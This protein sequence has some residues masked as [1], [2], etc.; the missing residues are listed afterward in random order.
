MNEDGFLAKII[1]GDLPTAPITR[2]LSWKFIE[3][4]ETTNTISVEMLARAEFINPAGLVHGGMLAAM[5][6]ETIAPAVA[7]TLGPGEFAP[8]LE[9]KVSFMA[10]AKPG[11][12]RGFGKVVSRGRTICF[13]EGRLLDD[14]DRLIAAATATF[15]IGSSQV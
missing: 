5:L 15:K 6:D 7:A 2:L 4:D 11:R 13:G 12:I 1:R 14:A 3:F 10:P 8:T 9:M